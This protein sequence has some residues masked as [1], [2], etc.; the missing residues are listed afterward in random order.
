MPVAVETQVLYIVVVRPAE[1][2]RLVHRPATKV[3]HCG[4]GCVA[5]QAGS[6]RVNT[7]TE[8]HGVALDVAVDAPVHDNHTP[9]S[10]ISFC[11][12]VAIGVPRMGRQ[13]AIGKCLVTSARLASRRVRRRG[14]QLQRR[15]VGVLA[16]HHAVLAS[17]VGGEWQVASVVGCIVGSG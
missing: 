7:D 14:R 10:Q 12:C 6:Q 5:N 15:G 8:W 13:G 16:L 4:V 3:H 11:V 9:T 1:H 2:L 17:T